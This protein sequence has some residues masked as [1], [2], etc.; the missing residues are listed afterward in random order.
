MDWSVWTSQQIAESIPRLVQLVE[1]RTQ[2]FSEN[3]RQKCVDTIAPLLTNNPSAESISARLEDLTALG[4]I[5]VTVARRVSSIEERL[6]LLHEAHELSRGGRALQVST[7][8]MR[9]AVNEAIRAIVNHEVD[10]ASKFQTDASTIH[11][12]LH[13]FVTSAWDSVPPQTGLLINELLFEKLNAALLERAGDSDF[14]RRLVRDNVET[15]LTIELPSRLEK[16]R[17]QWVDI[18]RH[19]APTAL[20]IATKATSRPQELSTVLATVRRDFDA[21]LVTASTELLTKAIETCE[22]GLVNNLRLR[23]DVEGEPI[24][25]MSELRIR[26]V[27]D[28]HFTEARQLLERNDPAARKKFEDLHYKRPSDPIVK[29]W[30][31]YAIKRF[32]TAGD[33]YEIIELLTDAKRSEYFR[34]ELSW[35][36]LWNL[37]CEM[38]TLPTSEHEALDVLL[39][40]LETDLHTASVFKLCL[41]WALDDEREDILPRLLAR[42]VFFEAQLLATLYE[43]HGGAQSQD[44]LTDEFK[45]VNRILRNL[46]QDFPLP[47]EKMTPDQLEALTREFVGNSMIFAGIE[48]FQQRMSVGGERYSYKN[49]QCLGRLYEEAGNKA[50]TWRCKTHEWDRTVKNKNTPNSRKRNALTPILRWAQQENFQRE[51]L[52]LLKRDARTVEMSPNDILLWERKLAVPADAPPAESW[53][54]PVSTPR[55]PVTLGEPT[56]GPVDGAEADRIVRTLAPTFARVTTADELADK[57]Q[58]ASRLLEASLVMNPTAPTAAVAALR[59]VIRLSVVFREGVDSPK[60]Q[61]LAVRMRD[62]IGPLSEHRARMPYELAGLMQACERAIQSLAVRV[63]AVSE[64]LVAQPSQM[65]SVLPRPMAG[66]TLITR[67]FTRISN[68]GSEEAREVQVEIIPGSSSVIPLENPVYVESL[69]PSQTSIVEFPLEIRPD[70]EAEVEL[71]VQV[72]C[73][74][75]RLTSS[76]TS[77]GQV[78]VQEFSVPIPALDRY[79]TD[80]PVPIDRADLFHGRSRE[81]RELGEAFAGGRLLRL[82]FVN[83]IRA[84]GKSSLMNHL[85]MHLGPDVLPILIN[86]QTVLA[87]PKMDS[88]QMVR[89][90]VR[91]AIRATAHLPQCPP[92]TLSPPDGEAFRL[93]PP[94]VVLDAFLERLLRTSGRQSALLALD[95]MQ[96]LV[97]RIADPDDPL[98]DG[99][100]S[101]LRDKIQTRSNVLVIC[102]GSEPYELMRKRYE[103]EHTVWRNIKPY[104]VSF[105]DRGAMESIATVPVRADGVHWLPEAL[106]RLWDT[107]EGHPWIVQQIA[108]EVTGELNTEMRRTVAPGDIDRATSRVVARPEVIGLW[109]NEKQGLVN[110]THK[111]IAYLVLQNQGGSRVGVPETELIALCKR[112]GIATSARYIEEM[113]AL[114]VLTRGEKGAEVQWRIRSAFLERH[115]AQMMQRELSEVGAPLGMHSSHR[116]L[117]LMLDWENIKISLMEVV[118]KM[119]RERA[120]AARSRLNADYLGAHLLKLAAGHGDARQRW[121]VA[122]WD[123]A[124]FSGE[125]KTLRGAGFWTEMAGSDKANASDHVLIEKI[126]YVLRGHPDIMVYVLGT[127]DGDYGSVVS[128]LRENGKD[129]ILWVPHEDAMSK[130][131]K[132]FLTGPDRISIEMLDSLV[133]GEESGATVS[134]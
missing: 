102:T 104:D 99:F 116:P 55:N 128:T 45:R 105:V 121:V 36:G 86:I 9:Q 110:P 70:V 134:H 76:G 44:E 14:E 100:L 119:P 72:R 10:R 42:A 109:W 129:V 107:T 30:L 34:I 85:G 47:H 18:A 62:Q 95:E 97:K 131:Y 51:G 16:M 46:D 126:H 27:P 108:A 31:A 43:L 22:D 33:K 59:E 60:A 82:N 5:V 117:A 63:R 38:R 13:R 6:S 80:Q 37:A 68:P 56:R 103:H 48:W 123:R 21:A 106:D 25:P 78:R 53:G 7:P 125:Q 122:D 96:V 17:D 75:G 4:L 94:M 41:L 64:I 130:A 101:W 67:V 61:E 113:K 132:H 73:R 71:R 35:Q 8:L 1:K 79:T 2:E 23:L 115:L 15:I 3:D 19:V 98:D 77:S 93:D 111:Q 133:L 84:V 91:E 20:A 29:E 74:V 120:E 69:A 66:T 88:I 114:E 40:V 26:N 12:L 57:S 127:G 24:K 11:S 52:R 28:R 87:A 39:P 124:L 89:G 50:A 83:G 90:I 65:R 81:L 118:N 112:S 54:A 32:G 58:D 49:W 92:G